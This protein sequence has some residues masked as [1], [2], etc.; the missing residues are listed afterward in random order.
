M[1]KLTWI[2]EKVLEREIKTK[3]NNFDGRKTRKFYI[4][5]EKTRKT[6]GHQGES[7]RQ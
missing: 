4:G 5:G 6:R 1:S 3:E 7:E 2:T